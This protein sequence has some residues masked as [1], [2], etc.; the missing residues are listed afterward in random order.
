MTLVR[1]GFPKLWVSF[2]RVAQSRWH[3][4]R[5]IRKRKSAAFAFELGDVVVWAVL[6]VSEITA[7]CLRTRACREFLTVTLHVRHGIGSSHGTAMVA[8]PP[9]VVSMFSLATSGDLS[10]RRGDVHRECW[11]SHTSSSELDATPKRVL[12]SKVRKEK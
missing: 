7:A 1:E 4:T 5:T 12:K 3:L 11:R 8:Q 6:S 2:F 9:I 10:E